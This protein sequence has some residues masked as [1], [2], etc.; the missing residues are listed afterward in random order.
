MFKHFIYLQWKAFFRSSSLG[1]SI[2]LKILMGFLAIY[3]AVIFLFLGIGL[4][5]LLTEFY[6]DQPPLH[7]ANRFVLLWLGMELVARFFLKTLPVMTVK[8]LLI[9]P[10]PKRK[11]VNYVLIKSLLSFYNLLPLLLIIPFGI[12][13]SY[14]TEVTPLAIIGWVIAV[15]S[16]ILCVDYGNFLLK[17]KF[18]DNLKA[19][20]PFLVLVAALVLLEYFDIFR[21]TLY[22]GNALD[23]LV[24]NPWLAIVPVVLLVILYKWNQRNLE[25]RFYLDDGLGGPSKEVN[26]QE[27]Q[28]V[29]RFGDIAPFLQLDMKLIW[30]NKRPKTTIFLSLVIMGY[31]LIF[32]PQETYQS[33]QTMFVFV[34]IFMTGIFMI[35]F[36]QFIPAW[37][38]TYYSM[39]MSQNIPLKK[40][41]ASKVGLITFS[42]IVLTILTTPY[43]YFGT[44]ILIMN[45]AC[46]IYNIGINVPILLY[47][48]SFNRKRIELEKSPFMNYQGTGAAQWLVGIPLIFIPVA[49]FW[50]LNKWVTYDVGVAVLAGLGLVGILLRKP[51][52]DFIERAY[53]KNKYAMIQG[54]KQTGE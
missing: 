11:V 54:F 29:R 15:Y 17:K 9:S 39:M 13:L 42:I 21:S 7:M 22:F 14:K 37:D 40:Y 45:I 10:V 2:G 19:L 33:M 36:G 30:R 28:W 16:L 53:Q 51:V 18:A 4:Y 44:N 25:R 3:F 31:G 48:G 43:V 23:Y 26:T 52:M 46:A 27:F 41:L 50:P 38:A 5:P 12:F 1:K 34:G 47:A 35:N 6:P 20:L 49:I 32:Y 24:L 8:P